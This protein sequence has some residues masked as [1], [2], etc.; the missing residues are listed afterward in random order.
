MRLITID[1][2]IY[3]LGHEFSL[4]SSKKFLRKSSMKFLKADK[5]CY[6]AFSMV[7]IIILFWCPNEGFVFMK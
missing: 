1:Y 7:L 3:S 2:S 6:L 5:T 4:S